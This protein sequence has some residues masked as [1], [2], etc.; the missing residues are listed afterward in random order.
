MGRIK[1][2]KRV[3][4]FVSVLFETESHRPRLALNFCTAKV[5]LEL[6]LPLSARIIGMLHHVWLAVCFMTPFTLT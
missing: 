6:S 4:L 2:G 3:H 1:S 5:D